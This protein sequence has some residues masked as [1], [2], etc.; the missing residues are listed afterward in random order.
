MTG[1]Y[2]AG[3]CNIGPSEIQQRRRV[4]Y[5]GAVLYV[6]TIIAFL[7]F[8]P[9]L[10]V[11]FFAL[12]PAMAFATGWVQSRRKFCLAFGLMGA[13]NFGPLGSVEQIASAED[14]AADRRTVYRLASE[15]LLI[16]SLLTV[17]AVLV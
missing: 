8:R 13:F 5:L 11:K 3:V 7:I 15:A 1:D 12:I 10:P 14:R 4:G 16:G 9:S 17:L 2:V 6:A